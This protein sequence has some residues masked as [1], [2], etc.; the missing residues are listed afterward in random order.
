MLGASCT[1]H[2]CIIHTFCPHNTT[3]SRPHPVNKHHDSVVI[4]FKFPARTEHQTVGAKSLQDARLVAARGLDSAI[5][6]IVAAR[7]PAFSN[8]AIAK[9]V[10]VDEKI[11]R[12]WRTGD[13]PLPAGALCMFSETLQ[14]AV[15]AEMGLVHPEPAPRVDLR[16]LRMESL[17]ARAERAIANA[18]RLVD[19]AQARRVR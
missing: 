17:K 16:R 18:R 15:L 10:G 12:Q 8:A 5:K 13:K 4:N 9:R 11:V 3:I 2:A 6:K 19:E 14:K 7:G 1:V